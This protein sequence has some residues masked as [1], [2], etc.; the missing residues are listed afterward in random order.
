MNKIKQYKVYPIVIILIISFAL[1]W[2]VADIYSTVSHARKYPKVENLKRSNGMIHHPTFGSYPEETP[3]VEGI[4]LM[5]GQ[6]PMAEIAIEIKLKD[7]KIQE[8][9]EEVIE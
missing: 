8:T 5:P 2:L 7:E 4:T 9:P 1:A 6:R 3:F